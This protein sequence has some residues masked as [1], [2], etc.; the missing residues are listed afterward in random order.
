MSGLP[1]FARYEEI[2]YQYGFHMGAMITDALLQAGLTWETIV[3]PRAQAVRQ[4]YP[5]AHTVSGFEAVLISEGAEKVLTWRDHEKPR[6]VC[7]ITSFLRQERIETA[8][9][10]K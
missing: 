2:N 10:L 1:K 4:N 9:D 7:E 8:Q 6:R 5:M 3:F